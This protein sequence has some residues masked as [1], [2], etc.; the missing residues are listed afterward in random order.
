MLLLSISPARAVITDYGKAIEA[1]SSTDTYIGPR[2]TLASEVWR[3][4]TGGPY[5]HKNDVWAFGYSIAEILGYCGA[6]ECGF[7]AIELKRYQ[8]MIEW[9]H[10]HATR[11]PED[12]DL[13]DLTVSMLSW[14]AAQR[15]TATEACEHKCWDVIEPHSDAEGTLKHLSKDLNSKKPRAHAQG[16]CY[17]LRSILGPI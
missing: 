8:A 14:D 5:A 9:L 12:S 1:E 10:N 3:V 4:S 2:H 13:I 16:A 17:K 15:P 11:C 6:A 7:A